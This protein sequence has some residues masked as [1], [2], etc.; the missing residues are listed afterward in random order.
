VYPSQGGYILEISSKKGTF[1]SLISPEDVPFVSSKKWYFDR[2]YVRLSK[3]GNLEGVARMILG[4]VKGQVVDHINGNTMDNRRENLRVCTQ[5]QNCMN[6]AN[7][8]GKLKGITFRKRG[9]CERYIVRISKKTIGYF[10]ELND[11][12][13]AYNTAVKEIHGEFARTHESLP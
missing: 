7:Y 11:A 9:E 5:S 8:P 12:I 4:A 2:G 10:K 1:Q 6:R 13:A 3:R